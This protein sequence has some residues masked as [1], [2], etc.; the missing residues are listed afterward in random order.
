MTNFGEQIREHMTVVSTDG[1][2]IGQVDHPEGEN[3]IKLTRD[4]EGK[5]HWIPIG[6]VTGVDNNLVHI[7]RSVTRAKSEWSDSSPADL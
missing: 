6:W 3:S 7:D 5:H 1:T 2:E 4:D